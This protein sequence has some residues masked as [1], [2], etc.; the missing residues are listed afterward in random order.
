MDPKPKKVIFVLEGAVVPGT[1]PEGYQPY[2]KFR[3]W[4]GLPRHAGQVEVVEVKTAA[5]VWTLFHG[6]TDIDIVVFF[7][8]S[9]TLRARELADGRF[10]VVILGETPS[11]PIGLIKADQDWVTNA[12]MTEKIILGLT[13]DD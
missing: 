6:G 3:G 8:R 13:D 12:T 11:S 7:S 10:R 1:D 4:L 9:M 2:K 5:D